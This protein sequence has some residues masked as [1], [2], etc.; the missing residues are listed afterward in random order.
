MK[1]T[2]ITAL[3]ALAASELLAIQ[4]S[5]STEAET[6][7]G[8]VKW[9]AREKKYVVEK[10]KITKEFKLA[11]VTELDIAKP[12]GYDKAV[13]AVEDGQGATAI[14]VLTKIVSDYRMLKWDKPAGRYL[15]LAHL[16]A[17]NA[18]KAYDACQPIIAEDK[19]AAY[20]GDLAA[21]YWQALLKLGKTEQLEGLLKKAASSSDR[22]SSA[23]ALVMRGDIIVA[24]SNGKPEELRNALR[25]GYLR[26]VLMYRDADCAR[27]RGEACMKAAACFDKLGQS[28]RA[29]K[30]RAEAKSI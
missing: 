10:G 3:A 12:A 22:A 26:V 11:D 15:A 30:L 14:P 27:E 7:S 8:D 5:V 25:D 29:E 28:S 9:H 13:Q 19:T 23:A 2:L 16:A 4:G 20:T 6:F 18:Q 24:A 1:K 21:A 17:G